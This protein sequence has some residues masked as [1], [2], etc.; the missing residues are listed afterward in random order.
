MIIKNTVFILGAGASKPFGFPTGLELKYYILNQLEVKNS[1]M[2][3]MLLQLIKDDIEIMEFCNS[4][5][6]SGLLSVDSFLEH[7][8]EFIKVGKL[9]IAYALINREDE[10]M[11]YQRNTGESWYEY[12]F[13]K[14][15]APFDTFE[16]NRVSFITFNYDRSLEHFLF[17]ALQSLSN[18]KSE[19]CAFILQRIMVKH[20]YGS[21]GQL[22]WQSSD[23]KSYSTKINPKILEKASN[24]IKIIS[25]KEK[26]ALVFKTAQNLLNNADYI[27]FLGF[28]YADNNLRRLNILNQ[29]M[30]TPMGTAKSIG[31]ADQ[32]RISDFWKISLFEY[33]NIEFLRNEVPWQYILQ[34]PK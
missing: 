13:G 7:R 21:L 11:L 14:M 17:N 32:N 30:K 22:S 33:T 34:P 5:N 16:E 19:R 20:I 6:K 1:P 26:K 23:G 4:L 18:E 24:Q 29:Q 9:A 8:T 15:N 10:Q 25:E 12:L 31:L 28:G 3:S 2:R 27:F